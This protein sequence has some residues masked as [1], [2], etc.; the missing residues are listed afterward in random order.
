MAGRTS[1]ARAGL[2]AAIA[3][4]TL[5]APVAA[6]PPGTAKPLGSGENLVA[7]AQFSVHVGVG[8][9][10][11]YYHPY[12]GRHYRAYPRPYYGP[13]Y[14]YR[15]APYYYPP[16]VTYYQT[17]PYVVRPVVPPVEYGGDPDALARCASRFKS[18][19]ANTG[20]YITYDGEERRCPYL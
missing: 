18:F 19:N 10:R 14:V 1:R 11:P 20:T 8:V 15:P 3:A 12:H 6:A 7:Q 13:G 5:A 17:Q 9:G 4:V 16:P 2:A